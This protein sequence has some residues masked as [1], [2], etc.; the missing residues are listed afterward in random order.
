MGGAARG[1]LFP[2]PR[3]GPLSRFWAYKVIGRVGEEAGLD[4][5]PHWFRAQRASPLV[6]DY[7]FEILGLIDFFGWTKHDMALTYA[8]KGGRGLAS[9]MR[10]TRYI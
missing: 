10:P 9:K 7:G 5:W 2:S 8:R 6:A 3:R 4:V 1:L